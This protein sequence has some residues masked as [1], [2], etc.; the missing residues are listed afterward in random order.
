VARD[1]L[2]DAGDFL[3]HRVAFRDC[4]IHAWG[5]FLPQAVYPGSVRL[6]IT[7]SGPAMRVARI[8]QL[9][10]GPPALP[11]LWWRGPVPSGWLVSN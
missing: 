9:K 4:G 1:A 6:G 8:A 2:D 7:I 3:R 5:L 10:T 11:D